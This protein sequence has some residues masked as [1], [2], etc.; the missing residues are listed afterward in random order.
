MK[1]ERLK[2]KFK[3]ASH[4]FGSNLKF[5]MEQRIPRVRTSSKLKNCFFVKFFISSPVHLQTLSSA[6]KLFRWFREI[7]CSSPWS[8]QKRLVQRAWE[9]R[10]SGRRRLHSWTASL[11]SRRSQFRGLARY[12]TWGATSTSTQSRRNDNS[13]NKHDAETILSFDVIHYGAN[14]SKCGQWSE[15]HHSRC[16]HNAL[17]DVEP[18]KQ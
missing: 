2:D 6:E 17:H 13:W 3:K 10:K 12:W 9:Q 1:K 18:T 4:F 16:R 5:I 11:L 7:S 14:D 15:Q 8:P